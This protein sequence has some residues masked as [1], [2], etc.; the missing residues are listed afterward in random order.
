MIDDRQAALAGLR[1]K[2]D[3]ELVALLAAHD[4]GEWEP[5]VFEMARQVLAERGVDV[6]AAV[7]AAAAAPPPE[8]LAPAPDG[9]EVV[10]TFGVLPDAEP[11]R[12]ALESAGFD[13]FLLDA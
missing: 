9:L 11:C 10:A 8:P 7:A 1:E 5:E 4:T 3:G 12:A 6:D 13:V 2:S